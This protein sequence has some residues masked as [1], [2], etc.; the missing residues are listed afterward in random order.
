MIWMGCRTIVPTIQTV[1]PLYLP[2][3]RFSKS[4]EKNDGLPH[5]PFTFA[6]LERKRREAYDL[7][8]KGKFSDALSSFRGL[9][10]LILFT[11]ADSTA[12]EKEVLF[13][14]TNNQI[15]DMVETC[16]EYILGMRLN[17]ARKDLSGDDSIKRGLEMAIYFTHCKMESVHLSLALH[18]AMKAMHKAK[19]YATAYLLAVRLL[20]LN[21]SP[22]IAQTVNFFKF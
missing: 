6:T 4:S 18:S 2:I 17:L 12:Q 9:L 16:R 14:H 22:Q 3:Q 1:T 15:K 21:P 8:T 5:V 7:T 10:Y 19:N 11:V 13:L 20:E